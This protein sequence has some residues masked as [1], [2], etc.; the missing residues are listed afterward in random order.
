[1][2]HLD[3]AEEIK[4]EGEYAA[5]AGD[6]V[7]GNLISTQSDVKYCRCTLFLLG[8]SERKEWKLRSIRKMM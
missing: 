8:R 3:D 6:M 7:R 4:Y 1:V 5:T 2:V